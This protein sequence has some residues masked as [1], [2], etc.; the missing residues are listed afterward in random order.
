MLPPTESPEMTTRSGLC[1]V[2]REVR[3]EHVAIGQADGPRQRQTQACGHR[4]HA[5]TV[6]ANEVFHATAS[7]H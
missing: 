1:V 5:G 6:L 4:I 2:Q 3:P 7:A